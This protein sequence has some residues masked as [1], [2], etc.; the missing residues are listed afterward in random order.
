MV[1]LKIGSRARHSCP[2]TARFRDVHATPTEPTP[3]PMQHSPKKV[4]KDIPIAQL[5][6]VQRSMADETNATGRL[7]LTTLPGLYNQLWLLLLQNRD[8]PVSSRKQ[9][10]LE[11]DEQTGCQTRVICHGI[12]LASRDST[13]WELW[14]AA[15]KAMVAHN[16][17]TDKQ[18]R[19]GMHLPAPSLPQCHSQ[20]HTPIG[21]CLSFELSPV[22]AGS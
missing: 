6:S 9:A 22:P 15:A 18:A 16:P 4:P 19:S 14:H 13:Q 20:P 5:R 3:T 12:Q 8:V 17:N 7:R 2:P 11:Q 21:A 10:I 1:L